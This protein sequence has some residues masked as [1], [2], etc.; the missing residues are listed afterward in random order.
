MRSICRFIGWFCYLV[1]AFGI[2]AGLWMHAVHAIVLS[3]IVILM[4][5]YFTNEHHGRATN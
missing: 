1:A 2:V 3:V 4:G 5:L